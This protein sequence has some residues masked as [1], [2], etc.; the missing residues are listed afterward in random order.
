[1][2]VHQKGKRGI[3]P[4]AILF[5]MVIFLINAYCCAGAAI[6]VESNTTTVRYNNGRLEES[7]IKYDLEL[8]FL[9][10]PYIG[11][12]LDSDP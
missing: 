12:V 2:E 8:E 7:L 1:M 6:V 5:V 9:M 4:V 10:N 3:Y 11:R